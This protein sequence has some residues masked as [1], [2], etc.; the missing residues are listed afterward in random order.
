M[1]FKGV[2]TLL[3]ALAKAPEHSFHIL[4]DGPE[5]VNLERISNELGPKNVVFHG[6]L[7]GKELENAFWGA[8]YAVVPSDCYET[9]SYA[10]QEA[11]SHGIPVIGS[12]LGAIPE[13][14]QEGETGYLFPAGN[15]DI[16]AQKIQKILENDENREKMGKNA[17]KFIENRCDRGKYAQN[18]LEMYEHLLGDC[19]GQV[20]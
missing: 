1:P 10:V 2:A 3:Q 19:R 17:Q 4:G 5:K 18:L 20:S 13:L 6:F 12:D 14:V 7:T 16:L 15:S 9:F 8:K 11:F